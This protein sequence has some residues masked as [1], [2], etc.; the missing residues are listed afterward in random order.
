MRRGLSIVEVMVAVAVLGVMVVSIFPVLGWMINKSQQLQYGNQ[1]SSVLA[2]GME[3]TYNVFLADWE[4]FG[5]CSGGCVYHPAVR[6][7]AV[8]GSWEWTL[9]D[10]EEADVEARFRRRVEIEEVCRRD[11]SG[12]IVE[13]GCG[14]GASIDANSRWVVG[15]VE[16]TEKG[17][18]REIS[19]RLL[20]TRL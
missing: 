20:L 8:P 15:T 2:E 9:L 1:A 14:S 12:E 18:E 10:G 11:D 13:G 17:Q 6:P 19:A 4:E 7:G 5:G 3:V 16:W